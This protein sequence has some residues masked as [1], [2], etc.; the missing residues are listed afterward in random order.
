MSTESMSPELWH[1]AW[2]VFWNWSL[3]LHVLSIEQK[4]KAADTEALILGCAL[5]ERMLEVES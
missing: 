1:Y 5:H 2:S 4:S 3:M